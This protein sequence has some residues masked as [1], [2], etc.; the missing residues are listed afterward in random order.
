MGRGAV[1]KF[2]SVDRA[3]ASIERFQAENNEMQM[4][5]RSK[6]IDCKDKKRTESSAAHVVN[7]S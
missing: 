3:L 1:V 5:Y 4:I 2:F 6:V 7:V